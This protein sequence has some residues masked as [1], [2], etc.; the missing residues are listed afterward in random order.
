MNFHALIQSEEV[1]VRHRATSAQPP[2]A[3]SPFLLWPSSRRARHP[4]PSTAVLDTPGVLL[5]G[6]RC[7]PVAYRLPATMWSHRK[8]GTSVFGDF[9]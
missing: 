8:N 9:Q 3:S 7:C 1:A 2:H 5:E 6:L 4:F